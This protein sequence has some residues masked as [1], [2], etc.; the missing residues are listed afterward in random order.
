MVITETVI[1]IS[2]VT[3]MIDFAKDLFFST[4]R[5]LSACGHVQAGKDTEKEKETGN[6]R[7]FFIHKFHSAA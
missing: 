6:Q 5:R 3:L 4:Q 7:H 2:S 1:L